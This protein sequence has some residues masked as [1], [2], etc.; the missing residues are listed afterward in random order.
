MAYRRPLILLVAALLLLSVPIVP[1]GSIK[2]AHAQAELSED[3]LRLG[4]Q[5]AELLGANEVY[6]TALN[7]QRRDI[8][9]AIGSTNPDILDVVTEVADVAY[10]DMVDTTGPLFTEIARLHATTYSEAELQELVTFFESDVGTRYLE[11]RRAVTQGTMQA[12]VQWGD[13]INSV[14]LA[15]VRAL[16]T[17]RG[18]QL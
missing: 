13:T 15:R 11:N 4:A 3:H 8:I 1:T 9:R 12:T 5:L 18:I 2:G 17:E 10:L 16:L 14:F 6:I 7:A